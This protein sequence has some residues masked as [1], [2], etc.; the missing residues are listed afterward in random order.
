MVCPFR[1]PVAMKT[2]VRVD[3]SKRWQYLFLALCIAIFGGLAIEQLIAQVD[4][5]NAWRR[6]VRG[7][8]YAHSVQASSSPTFRSTVPSEPSALSS[9]RQWHRIILPIAV[10][11]F[12]VTFSCWLL[13]GVP[14]R[15]II[16]RLEG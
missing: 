15:G 8:E 9:T 11:S 10:G 6:T 14:N 1:N 16:R 7:W 5:Q 3:I 13:V 12:L 2:R 4:G